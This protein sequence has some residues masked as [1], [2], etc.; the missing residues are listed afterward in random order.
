VVVIRIASQKMVVEKISVERVLSVEL[1]SAD[2]SGVGGL[3]EYSM[4]LDNLG[5]ASSTSCK[6]VRRRSLNTLY[7][8]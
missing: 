1:A 8:I 3:R 5:L 2:P 4:F 7:I 6:L